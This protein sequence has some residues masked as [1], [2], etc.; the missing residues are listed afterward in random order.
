MR[1]HREP[2]PDI[3]QRYVA[4]IA[5]REV[6]PDIDARHDDGGIQTVT[7]PEMEQ[8]VVKHL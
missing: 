4:G 2:V 7:R 3:A 1:R 5:E 8:V 6:R